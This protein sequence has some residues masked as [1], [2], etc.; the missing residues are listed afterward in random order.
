M[1]SAMGASKLQAEWKQNMAV[2]A[3]RPDLE[4]GGLRLLR[5][6]G[7]GRYLSFPKSPSVKEFREITPDRM[8]RP[9]L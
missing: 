9:R 6:P 8:D 5:D 4:H 1:Q 7:D 2:P 3:R